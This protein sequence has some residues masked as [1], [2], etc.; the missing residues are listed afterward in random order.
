MSQTSWTAGDVSGS[1]TL[2]D[3]DHVY[4]GHWN[5]LRVAVNALEAILDPDTSLLTSP[6]ITSMQINDTSADHQYVFAVNELTAD[7]T[8]TLPLLTGNDEFV[9]KDHTQTLTNKTL[10]SP[11]I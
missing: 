5:E 7:R 2:V 8:V 4:P 6:V 1:Q 11:T 9:F 3:N 10:T